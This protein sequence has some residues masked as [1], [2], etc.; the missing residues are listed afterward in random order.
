MRRFFRGYLRLLIS[1]FD[2]LV[3]GFFGASGRLVGLDFLYWF[4]E[5]SEVGNY[6][7]FFFLLSYG[8][9][10]LIVIGFPVLG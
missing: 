6:V 3:N 4:S 10:E 7:D 5:V 2:V 9:V 8:A 1:C